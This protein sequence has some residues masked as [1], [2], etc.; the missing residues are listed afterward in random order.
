[1]R[2]S[3]DLYAFRI[4]SGVEQK[5]LGPLNGDVLSFQSSAEV[6]KV[7]D[8]RRGRRGQNMKVFTDPAA[9]TG[10]LKLYSVPPRILAM[11]MLGK[12]V[13]R[14]DAGGTVT[15]EEVTIEPDY[16]TPLAQ[17]HISGVTVTSDPVGTT[18][19][20]GT[21]YEIDDKLGLIRAIEG[22][23]L[24]ASTAVLVSYAHKAVTGDRIEV[25]T[26]YTVRARLLLR[27]VNDS[28]DS[29]IEWEAYQ[30]LLTPSGEFDLLSA[31]PVSAEFSL[32]FETPD[33]QDHPI[34]LDFPVYAA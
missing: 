19:V 32:E 34:R 4:V 5:G 11:L 28:D 23:T 33:A 9:P 29:A 22:S 3:G 10:T 16:W 12:I 20:A 7:A 8:K 30:A 1:M 26:D 24:T 6:V 15:D 25:G 18:Y 21:H 31:E 14:S 27:G 13:S 2:L 17:A